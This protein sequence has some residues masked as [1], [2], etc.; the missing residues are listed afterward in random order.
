MARF[1]R[2]PFLLRMMLWDRTTARRLTALALLALC[3]LA[4]RAAGA[5]V[6]E[7]PIPFDSGGHILAITPPLAARLGLAPPAWPVSGDYV[8]ARLY[9]VEDST[10]R[11]V[12]IVRRQRD[13]LERYSLA[14]T[15]RLELAAAVNRGVVAQRA[16]GGP[17]SL[18][19]RISDP[20]RGWFVVNQSVLGVALFAPAA[21]ALTGNP[22]AGTAAYLAVA[23][24]TFFFAA[25]RARRIPVSSAENH[26]AWHGARHGAAAA[27]LAAYALGGE[28]MD[29]KAVAG[30]LLA[31]GIIG[32]VTGYRV[33]RPMTDAEAHGVSHGAFVSSAIMAG[34]LGA[35]NMWDNEGSSRAAAAIVLGAGIVGYPL[36][37][38]YARSRSYR[39][40][41]GDVGTLPVGEWLGAIAVASF[42]P[43]DADNEHLI[44]A[45]VTGGFLAG[46]VGA[47]RLL[48]RRFDYGES[49]SRLLQLGT[50]AGA[51][52]GLA[53]PVLA[54]SENPQ[55]IFIPA[56][57]GG[58]LG[59]ILTHSLI[60]PAR[61][62]SAAGMRTGARSTSERV[63][64]RF[65]R[66]N[67][68]LARAGG[69]GLY[70]V[71]GVEF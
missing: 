29:E 18:A 53:I 32:D 70:P 3:T 16:A 13:V 21:A 69:R 38:R 7:R 61:A 71:L 68:F 36:G 51:V 35:A 62:G 23:G 40:T 11:A 6:R 34:T 9:V 33:A 50:A 27:G 1:L 65:T 52:V 60:A 57:V 22:A 14:P 37:L 42:I 59:A 2:S 31:G 56:T 39:V 17:E 46:A 28:N 49:E 41:A 8:D 63:T 20:V 24:G 43:E 55:A 48:V 19:T 58:I 12:L 64:L 25:E 30:A 54:Q 44:A 45:L 66:Q 47:D 67:L 5:Q 10:S 26:L 4:P 15:Q